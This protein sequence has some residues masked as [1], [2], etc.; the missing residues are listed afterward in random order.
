MLKPLSWEL[1]RGCADIFVT[2]PRRP[3]ALL[4]RR[5]TATERS[6]LPLISWRTVHSKSSSKTA[7]FLAL[8]MRL[9]FQIKR[10]RKGVKVCL[11]RD[12]SMCGLNLPQEM[13]V[14][15]WSKTRCCT[16]AGGAVHHLA[17]VF[18]GRY[19]CRMVHLMHEL[20]IG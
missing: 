8:L 12:C 18:V 1:R 11:V 15:R 17:E 5:S 2:Y 6:N 3:G 13:T 7:L 14:R 10:K 4:Q 16:N 19:I 20:C 9:Y